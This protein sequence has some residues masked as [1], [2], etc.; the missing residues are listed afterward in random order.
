MQR[1]HRTRALI[2]ARELLTGLERNRRG[3]VLGRGQRPLGCTTIITTAIDAILARQ[4]TVG[5]EGSGACNHEECRAARA[6]YASFGNYDFT[7]CTRAQAA[8]QGF[9][10]RA[11]QWARH[12]HDDRAGCWGAEARGDSWAPTASGSPRRD[13]STQEGPGHQAIPQTHTLLKYPITP[14]GDRSLAGT[15][16]AAV[17]GEGNCTKAREGL[18]G[19]R[20]WPSPRL[21]TESMSRIVVGGP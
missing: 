13:A 4:H 21:D 16:S 19:T 3:I 14:S 10:S 8:C 1:H 5:S 17:A 15:L 7:P 12:M 6:H 2:A 11:A 9:V 18:R 20:D